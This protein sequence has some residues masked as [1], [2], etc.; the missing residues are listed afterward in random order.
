MRI[1]SGRQRPHAGVRSRAVMKAHHKPILF[2]EILVEKVLRVL[3]GERLEAEP[4]P[5]DSPPR[6]LAH[7]S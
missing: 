5:V 7:D 2:S 3:K 1:L 4:L 6:P